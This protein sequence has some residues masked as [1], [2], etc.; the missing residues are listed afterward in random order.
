MDLGFILLVPAV[1]AV[2]MLTR[3]MDKQQKTLEKINQNLQSLVDRKN[4]I[5]SESKIGK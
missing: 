1:V 3:Q 4:L 2:L 5:D